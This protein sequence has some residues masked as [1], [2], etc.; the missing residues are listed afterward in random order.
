MVCIDCNQE[1]NLLT[2][3]W[4]E[5]HQ[6][7]AT[8]AKFIGYFESIPLY[9]IHGRHSHSGSTVDANSLIS[10]GIEVPPTPSLE[11]WKKERVA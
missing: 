11:E 1:I 3:S 2:L 8:Y 9:N 7:R 5:T 4:H 6:L 10:F